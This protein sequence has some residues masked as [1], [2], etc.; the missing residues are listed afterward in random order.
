[1]LIIF[2]W[3]G[4]WF[5]LMFIVAYALTKIFVPW[6]TYLSIVVRAFKTDPNKGDLPRD[7]LLVEKAT[8]KELIKLA[9]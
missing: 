8:P 5:T 1:V 6:F 7:P 4:G 2:A 9:K 3:L